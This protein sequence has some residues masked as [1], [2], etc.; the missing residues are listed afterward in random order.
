MAVVEEMLE[1]G[2]LVPVRGWYAL[3][4][5]LRVT[6]R[7]NVETLANGTQ[8]L[9]A[10]K[11]CS[12]REA[13]L[14]GVKADSFYFEEEFAIGTL[15]EI[16]LRSENCPFCRLI[17]SAICDGPRISESGLPED[18]ITVEYYYGHRGFVATGTRLGTLVARVGTN[19]EGNVDKEKRGRVVTRTEIDPALIGRWV[20]ACEDHHDNECQPKP[21]AMS[22]PEGVSGFSMA[23]RNLRFIDVHDRCIVDAPAQCRYLALSYVWG[24]VPTVH[25]RR[26]NISQLMKPSGLATIHE[27]IPLTIR[28]AMELVS[29]LGER[30]LWVDSLCLIEDDEDDMREGIR[31]MDLVYEGSYL[32]IVAAS[33]AHA[34]AGLPGV[35]RGSRIAGQC[36]EEVK[37][38]VKVVVLRELDDYLFVSKYSSRGWT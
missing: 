12:T 36:V 6:E 31:T 16:R 21:W 1:T 27:D 28:D 32:T 2:E 24:L 30:Y 23:C 9:P 18:V 19:G 20:R 7:R 8:L 5:Y 34:N 33:G 13:S 14:A 11:L 10:K 15:L 38:G 29:I 3:P 22:E 37:P 26:D 35:R 25:L 4:S 17:Y